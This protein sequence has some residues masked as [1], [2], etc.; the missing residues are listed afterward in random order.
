MART[1]A[2]TRGAVA[3]VAVA[4]VAAVEI[5]AVEIAASVSA[6]SRGIETVSGSVDTGGSRLKLHLGLVPSSGP[7][8]GAVSASVPIRRWRSRRVAEDRRDPD[9]APDDSDGVLPLALSVSF[10]SIAT[11]A[12]DG[13]DA[14]GALAR[15]RAVSQ[16]AVRNASVAARYA[17]LG[18]GPG[19]CPGGSPRVEDAR[20]DGGGDGDSRTS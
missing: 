8:K 16:A 2:G 4:A 15:S 6:S 7:E 14:R 17:G 3:A 10:H 12:V 18:P 13:S 9:R 5:A 1:A 19:P 20:R 11:F